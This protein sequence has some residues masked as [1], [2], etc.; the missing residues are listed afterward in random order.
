MKPPT[1]TRR[2]IA[3]TLSVPTFVISLY[4]IPNA[5]IRTA[6][7]HRNQIDSGFAIGVS[8]WCL[9]AWMAWRGIRYAFNPQSWNIPRVN[10][11][12]VSLGLVL[13]AVNVNLTLRPERATFKAANSSEQTGMWIAAVAMIAG[14][15]CLVYSGV[16]DKKKFFLPSIA[17]E[18]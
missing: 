2:V 6:I 9:M 17:A 3:G 13:I 7:L 14:G 18:Q 8:L 10:S 11:I 16:S 5:I 1:L 15:L 12:K 4:T